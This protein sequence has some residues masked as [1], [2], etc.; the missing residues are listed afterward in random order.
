MRRNHANQ[1]TAILGATLVKAQSEGTL[2]NA[3]ETMAELVRRLFD[4]RN[5][6]R[7][8]ARVL[9][10]AYTHDSAPPQEAVT[11]ALTYPVK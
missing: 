4:E 8:C 2:M 7:A 6:A 5:E 1:S 11:Q 9:A 10:H 3:P